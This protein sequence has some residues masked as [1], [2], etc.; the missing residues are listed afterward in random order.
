MIQSTLVGTQKSE[1]AS[2]QFFIINEASPY[3]QL[4]L[5]ILVVF[6]FFTFL[7][8][9]AANKDCIKTLLLFATASTSVTKY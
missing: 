9:C 8:L 3:A 4:V 2:G 5:L 6:R 1:L 7:V